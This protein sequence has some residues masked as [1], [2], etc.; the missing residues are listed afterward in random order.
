[1]VLDALEA[2]GREVVGFLDDECGPENRVFCEYPLLPSSNLEGVHP[3][4]DIVV[5]IG[6]CDVRAQVTQRV[7]ESGRS[8]TSV[9]HPSAAIARGVELGE[10]VMILAQ[11]AVNIDTHLGDGVIVN[12]GA[13]V[14]HDCVIGDFAHIAP[15]VHLAGN[16]RVGERSLVGI[17][18]MV[19]P[20][21]HI[22]EGA[23][24]GAG[25]VVVSE[26][27]DESVV[28]GNPAQAIGRAG[29]GGAGPH[30]AGVGDA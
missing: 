22:G 3:E 4:A 18:A 8:L 20:G 12:T 25:A 10:G 14:D 1:M 19:I 29:Q 23:V 6:G 27:H 11:V 24:V 21:M 16:V 5:A 2:S 30:L 28:V 9:V 13:T 26:V 15:G 7:R 17:G